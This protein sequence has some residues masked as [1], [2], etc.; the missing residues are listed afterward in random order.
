[1]NAENVWRYEKSIGVPWSTFQ[2]SHLF[3]IRG[4]IR[5]WYA[6]FC[7]AVLQ[8]LFK[9]MACMFS[10]TVIFVFSLKGYNGYKR[11]S[12]RVVC[13]NHNKGLG[14]VKMLQLKFHEVR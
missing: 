12:S 9:A 10:E 1:M 2:P 8:E 3:I 11:A 13:A 6:L 14:S 4:V 7:R 5:W